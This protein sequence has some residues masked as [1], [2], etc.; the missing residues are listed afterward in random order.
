MSGPSSAARSKYCRALAKSPCAIH[1]APA[2]ACAVAL[3]GLVRTLSSHIRNGSSQTHVWW[4]STQ[5]A[6]TSRS[7]QANPK[8]R[9]RAWEV[10]RATIC[11]RTQARRT[12]RPSDEAIYGRWSLTVCDSGKNE[13]SGASVTKNHA[14]AKVT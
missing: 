10:N 11:Q 6:G 14:E 2:L 12:A 3:L 13:D 8:A 9:G 7:E 5:T 1:R 4:R